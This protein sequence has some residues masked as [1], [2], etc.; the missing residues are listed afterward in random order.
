MEYVS[1]IFMIFAG[2]FNAYMDVSKQK[3]NISIFRF[4]GYEKWMNPA[5]SWK[6][7]WKDDGSGTYKKEKFFG[8][9]TFLVWLTDFWHFSK[10]MMILNICISI[11]CYKPLFSWHIDLLI[12]YLSFTITFEL[13]WNYILIKK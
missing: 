6:N 5:I 3:W 13:F 1:I 4:I 8:S 12:F 10:A 11:I 2:I 7:K 9:S